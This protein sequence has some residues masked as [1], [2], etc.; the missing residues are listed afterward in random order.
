MA[1]ENPT[2]NMA[3]KENAT[4]IGILLSDV[5]PQEVD[6]LWH[7]RLALGKLP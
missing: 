4:P 7:R 5:Q 2:Q 1:A 6:W 3:D